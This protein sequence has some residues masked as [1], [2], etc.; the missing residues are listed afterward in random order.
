MFAAALKESDSQDRAKRDKARQEKEA[1]AARQ[2]AARAQADALVAA[3]R[4]LDRAIQAV[5]DAKRNGK[6]TVEAD[7]AWKSAK[8]LVIELETGAAP[9]WAP[10]VAPTD[11]AE[12]EDGAEPGG[13]DD[14]VSEPPS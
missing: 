7:A 11:Q 8:A 6:S 13:E 12:E 10:V 3:R 4:D 5:R 2:A 14:A 9:T 1:E